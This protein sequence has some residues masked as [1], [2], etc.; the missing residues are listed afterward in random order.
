MSAFCLQSRWSRD[1]VKM[2]GFELATIFVAPSDFKSFWE[3]DSQKLVGVFFGAEPFLHHPALAR[4]L[5]ATRPRG[6]SGP[7]LGPLAAS[8]GDLWRPLLDSLLSCFFS[9]LSSLLSL[10]SSLFA[11]L[12][13]PCRRGLARPRSHESSHPLDSLPHYPWPGGMREAIK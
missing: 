6:L 2:Q 4:C 3:T 12:S 5:A 7:L 9:L 11:L 10:L 8:F 1:P 13:S